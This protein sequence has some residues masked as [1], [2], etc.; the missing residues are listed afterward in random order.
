MFVRCLCV[1]RDPGPEGPA[2]PDGTGVRERVGRGAA[3]PGPGNKGDLGR[4]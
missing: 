2:A 3:G 4:G 1:N